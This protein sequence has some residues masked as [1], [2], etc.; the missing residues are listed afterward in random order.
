[1][2]TKASI[3]TRPLKW[4]TT[5]A[6]VVLA[7]AWTFTLC[8][9][10]LRMGYD[11]I[12]DQPQFAIADGYLAINPGLGWTDAEPSRGVYLGLIAFSLP[13]M[14]ILLLLPTLGFWWLD[15][16]TPRAQNPS[17]ASRTQH[18][19]SDHSCAAHPA[20]KSKLHPR[21]AGG[22][23]SL[24]F[25][26]RLCAVLWSLL[27]TLVLL[28]FIG[29][30]DYQWPGM[31]IAADRGTLFLWLNPPASHETTRF[32]FS[33]HVRCGFDS[34]GPPAASTILVTGVEDVYWHYLGSV[35]DIEWQIEF[36][37]S[38]NGGTRYTCLP[39]WIPLAALTA[40]LLLLFAFDRPRHLSP[41]RCPHCG[42]NLTANTSARCPECG[43][44]VTA[45]SPTPAKDG[46]A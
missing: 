45:P 33:S 26:K 40:L 41:N 25:L 28:T 24:R 11:P 21:F 17:R 16:R 44:P 8:G 19:L 30:L 31:E 39:L 29:R 34:E 43:S 38:V 1:M 2:T 5:I 20:R 14:L 36:T 23:R 37:S 32:R 4:L 27:A 18:E 22:R 35:T 6:C 42:Y 7:G 10:S 3:L 12:V 13:G 15:R 9:G 46:S